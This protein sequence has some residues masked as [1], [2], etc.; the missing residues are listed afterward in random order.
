MDAS[1]I[2]VSLRCFGGVSVSAGGLSA[3]DG[4][5]GGCGVA[6]QVAEGAEAVRAG[7]EGGAGAGEQAGDLASGDADDGGVDGE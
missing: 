6:A 2:K 7:G 4:D 3:G 5:S 1:L